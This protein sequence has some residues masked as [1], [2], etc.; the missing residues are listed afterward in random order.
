MNIND[1]VYH[2]HNG[3]A[4][5]A[6]EF[7]GCHPDCRE[8]REG[9]VFRVWAPNA[10]KVSV[11]GDFNFWNPDDLPMYKISGGIWEVFSVHAK[12]GNA[13]KYAVTGPN[14]QSVYKA[15][16]VG[17][18]T[19]RLP[20]TS[21]VIWRQGQYKWH[22][23]LHFA[24]SARRDPLHIPMNI[25]EVHLG[26]W[27]R[28]ADGTVYTYREIAPGLAEYVKELGFTHVEL[29][30]LADYPFDPSWGYQVTNYY[31][32]TARYGTPDD[33]KFLVDTLHQAGIG[34]LL[35]WVPAHFP[36]DIYALYEFDGTCCYELSDPQMNEHPDWTTRIFDF[37]KPEVR[38]FLISCAVYW[39]TEFHLDGLRVDAVSSMLYLDYSRPNYRP[40]RYGGRENLEAIEFLRLLNE[41][42]YKV[43]KGVIMAAEE[44]HAFPRVTGPVSD[45]GLGFLLKWNMGWMNDTLRYFKEDPLF[46][47]Y[48]HGKLT[49]SMA[50]AFAENFILPLSHDEVVHGKYSLINKMPGDYFWK[51]AGL[52]LLRGYQMTHPGK[53]LSFMGNEFGQFIEWNYA[54]GLDWMLLDYDM[55][56]KMLHF[57]RELNRFYLE[58]DMLWA[59]DHSWEG[60]QWIQP[61]DA[62]NSVLA[63]RRINPKTKKELIVVMN[64]TPVSRHD[65]RLGVPKD[66]IYEPVFCSDDLYFGGTGEGAKTVSA[67]EVGFREYKHSALFH[68]P[69]MSMTIYKRQT[70]RKNGD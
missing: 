61:D 39:L 56:K 67:E 48:H 20:D 49:F 69:P 64:M 31:A 35:D 65:F 25:Y 14:G 3:S 37:G 9:F 24:R 13:Y 12:E 66:G 36:K 70:G 62:D 27:K 10:Q 38:S 22:D 50:Y 21:T 29:M 33:L 6:W 60:Y 51:F 2:Y 47:K 32:P 16:P 54:Q 4:T 28:K 26:S 15:D 17:F 23:S 18:R 43:R 7:L 30:P 5:H 68:V 19:C 52:R 45:G 1:H 40:N 55:H 46:R 59:D 8:G 63:W 53:K 44:S 57:T 42:C 34:V 58:N 41:A 11:V